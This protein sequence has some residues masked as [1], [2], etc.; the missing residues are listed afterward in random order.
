MRSDSI[1]MPKNLD[2]SLEREQS[3][4]SLVKNYYSPRKLNAPVSSLATT[5]IKPFGNS[6]N[7]DKSLKAFRPK[8]NEIGLG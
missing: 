3:P 7:D 5:K 1:Q 8:I 4:F 6:R 2:K